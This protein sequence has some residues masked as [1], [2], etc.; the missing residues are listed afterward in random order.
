MTIHRAE[1]EAALLL[2]VRGLDAG[3]RALVRHANAALLAYLDQWTG[4]DQRAEAVRLCGLARV[5]MGEK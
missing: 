1:A 3:D 2:Y 4:E 5:M